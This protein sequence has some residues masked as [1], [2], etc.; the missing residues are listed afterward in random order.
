MFKPG[1]F[2]DEIARG[3]ADNLLRNKLAKK[4][5]LADDLTKAVE[6][7][8][9]A[10]EIFDDTGFIAEAEAIVSMLEKLADKKKDLK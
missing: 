5:K 6:H 4:N 2:G 3:M 7:L 9:V 10:A 8:Q 1:N